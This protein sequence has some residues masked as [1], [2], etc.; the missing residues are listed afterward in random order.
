MIP[1]RPAFLAFAV[2]SIVLG[3]AAA[4]TAEGQDIAYPEGYRYWPTVK[5]YLNGPDMVTFAANGGFRHTYA[6]TKALEGYKTGKFPEGSVL[7]DERVEIAVAD[8]V[9]RETRRVNVNVMVKDTKRYAASGG[10][11]FETFKND[12]RVSAI[13]PEIKANCHACHTQVQDRDLVFSRFRE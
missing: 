4:A 3:V 1:T 9:V 6:N 13:T 2:L 8:G 12:V 7:V 10:W 11:G 5:T